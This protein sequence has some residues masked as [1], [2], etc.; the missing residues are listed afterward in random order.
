M[1]H[2]IHHL[3]SFKSKGKKGAE[4]LGLLLPWEFKSKETG[5]EGY[6]YSSMSEQGHDFL[7]V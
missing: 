1:N 3:F 5:Q 4:Q 2:K 6:V 7:H